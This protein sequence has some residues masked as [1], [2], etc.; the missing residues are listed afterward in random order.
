MRRHQHANDRIAQRFF[1]AKLVLLAH[2]TPLARL[3][4]IYRFGLNPAY[5]RGAL[6]VVWL[7]SPGRSP[8]AAGHVAAR[9]RVAPGSVC[10]LR[11]LVPRA[12]LRRN[13]RGVWV[14]PRVIPASCFVS[15]RPGAFAVP[16]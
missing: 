1:V 3:A 9:H 14:C 7:H 2:A 5:S 13:R 8:W 16:A 12:W 11:V 4:S 15:V 6:P 10:V